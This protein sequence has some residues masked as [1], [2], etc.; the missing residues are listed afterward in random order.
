[1]TRTSELRWAVTYVAMAVIIWHL[2]YIF[3]VLHH[4]FLAA[5]YGAMS[6]LHLY[7]AYKSYRRARTLK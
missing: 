7:A 3:E 4:P 6:G 5:L 2:S 1:M